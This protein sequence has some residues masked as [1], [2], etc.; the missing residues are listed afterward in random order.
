[1]DIDHRGFGISK[2]DK[3][4][5]FT[6]GLMPGDVGWIQI[7]KKIKGVW[8]AKLHKLQTKSV[9][10][11]KPACSFAQECGSCSIQ[12]I[13]YEYQLELKKKLLINT[14]RKIARLE[15]HLEDFVSLETLSFNYRNK[16]QLPLSTENKR[17][18]MGYFKKNTHSIVDIDS[19]P[20]LASPIDLILSS[21]KFDLS[22]IGL[23][24]RHDINP[25][26]KCIRY[27]LIRSSNIDNKL[28][29]CIVATYD[30]STQIKLLASKW[31]NNYN[32][33][34]GISININNI[35]NNRVLGTK[36]IH[37]AGYSSL[38]IRFC[39]LTYCLD[40]NCFFQVNVVIAE[41]VVNL[42]LDWLKLFPCSRIVD[43][44]C[45]IGT[46]SL[47]LAKYGYKVIGIEVNTASVN[48]A[49]INAKN[50]SINFAEFIEG[51]TTKLLGEILE[52]TDCLILD[53][54]RKGLDEKAISLILQKKPCRIAYLSCNPAT[55][56]R[57]I[58]R[59][60]KD[61]DYNLTQLIPADFFPQ[62]MHIECLAFLKKSSS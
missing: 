8:N 41:L 56:A 19:C 17:L 3:N 49:R 29:V 42:I 13:S 23:L 2:V 34:L 27:C 62:T 14:F 22:N 39:N 18:V 37:V 10:R 15:V 7:E 50:N 48:Y 9:N 30:C 57:D 1:M 25:G 26:D 4:I 36:N 55:L 38:D 40:S 44:Y 35:A 28:L 54:P 59:L 20:V 31:L 61:K 60:V 53:P 11:V 52:S 32:S 5:I 58:K 12:H 24:A 6:P 43:C 47:P 51:D 21:I 16:A 46:I 45:G 33:I